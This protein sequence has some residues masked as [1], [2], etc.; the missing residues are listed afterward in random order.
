MWEPDYAT[1]EL[2]KQWT[3]SG[4]G[5]SEVDTADDYA[6]SLALSAASRA[7]DRFVSQHVPRQFGLTDQIESRY[8]TARWDR[9]AL[10]W[11]I[12]IDD[13]EQISIDEFFEVWIDTSNQDQFNQQVTSYIMRDRN[14]VQNKRPYTQISIL[15]QESN[16]P[17]Y[18]KDSVR[19]DTRWGWSAFPVPVV[20]ATM[21][22]VNRVHKRRQAPFGASGGNVGAATGGGNRDRTQTTDSLQFKLDDDI[23]V[24]LQPYIKAGWTV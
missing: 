8:Y 1:T 15:P 16:Q 3:A 21:L 20:E 24:M 9:I 13:V 4:Y 18:F 2:Y 11:V 17:T 19:V 10:R 12:E 22:Q 7:I 23:E 5:Q 14:A 6:I